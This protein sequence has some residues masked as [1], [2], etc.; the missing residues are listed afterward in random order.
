MKIKSLSIFIFAFNEGE[1]IASVIEKCAL[2]IQTYVIDGELIVI[3]DGSTDN[4]SLI[5][6]KLSK[7][8]TFKCIEHSI[9]LGI[10]RALKNGY[11][12]AKKDFVVGVPGDGQFD[13]EELLLIKEW[14]EQKFYSFYREQK[15]YNYYRSFLTAFNKFLIKKLIKNN[16]KDVNWIKV[17]SKKHLILANPQ[18]ES[19]LIE[20]EISS[21][22][23]KK[24][25][26]FVELPSNYYPRIAGEPKGGNIYTV[27]KAFFEM[28]KLIKIVQKF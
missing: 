16:L 4:T 27:S 11:S 15:S 2:F 23:I 20:S 1:N 3:N 17:Y 24:E 21:K 26:K 18:L 13:I 19:S 12:H 28:L 9:N 8:Y 14:N 5:L 6:N 25:C 22:L 7:K 10:G